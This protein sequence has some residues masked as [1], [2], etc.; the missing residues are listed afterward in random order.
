MKKEKKE[1]NKIKYVPK[2]GKSAVAAYFILRLL[3]L[4]CLIIQIIHENWSNVFTCGLTLILFMVPS[5]LERKM[6][7]DLPNVLE[8]I[9]LLFIF[10]AEIL[11][12]IQAYYVI[13]PRW[14]DMLHTM[15]GFLA[16]AIGFALID[17]LNRSD[18]VHLSLSPGFVALVAFCFSMTVGVVWEFFE[19]S[20]DLWFGGDMQKDTWLQAFNSVTVHPEGLNEPVRI[21]I[22]EV[23]VNGDKWKGYLDIGLLDT[24]HDLFVNFL[25]AITFS[26]LG[27]LY[28]KN[29]GKG[30]ASKFI[31]VK[32]TSKED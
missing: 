24:M 14:D 32:N 1:K 10:A 9:I 23:I 27:L 15:N 26:I 8:V 6:D 11:G 17:I 7:V 4:A 30:V 21:K 25:G 2:R 18:K 16:A 22:E 28:I 5:I 12:E 20:M 19:C 29:R 3:V 13:F 31:P